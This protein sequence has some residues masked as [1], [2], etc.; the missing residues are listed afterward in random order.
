MQQASKH[1]IHDE[2]CAGLSCMFM[3]MSFFLGLSVCVYV[4]GME[5]VDSGVR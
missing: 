3:F 5:D 4:C 1:P 2:S